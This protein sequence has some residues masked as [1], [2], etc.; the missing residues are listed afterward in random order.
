[1][2]SSA[3]WNNYMWKFWLKDRFIEPY[4]PQKNPSDYEAMGKQ[5]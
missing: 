3:F 2:Q 4:N 5:N 1:M